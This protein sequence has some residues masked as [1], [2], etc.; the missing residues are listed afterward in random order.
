ME[1][2][3]NFVVECLKADIEKKIG[4]NLL[5]PSDFNYLSLQI[6]MTCNEQL[7]SHTI[8]RIWGYVRSKSKPSIHSLSLLCRFLGFYSFAHY[9]LDLNLKKSSSSSFIPTDLLVADVL[10]EGDYVSLK[11]NPDREVT[12]T[13][14]GNFMF[15]VIE[16]KN[17]RLVA[18]DEFQ[19][20]SFAKGA[21]FVALMSSNEASSKTSYI[22]G[23]QGGLT[24]ISIARKKGD[25]ENIMPASDH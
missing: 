25:S 15:R 7:S 16:S 8:M 11:W 18:G 23:K 14:L 21:P 6:N 5:T 9:T 19:C 17:S 20:M 24:S 12:L 4:R 3:I 2:N 10:K 1:S 22:G 13:Y